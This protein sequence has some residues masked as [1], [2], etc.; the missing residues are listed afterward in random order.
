MKPLKES[1]KASGS[2]SAIRKF[3][4][5]ISSKMPDV[6]N[7]G[8]GEPDFDTPKNIKEAAKKALDEGFT[9][10]TPNAGI[11]ELREAIA[12]K[13][14]EE[15]RIEANPETEIIVT[16][17]GMQA[18]HFALSS[19]LDK[20]DKVLVPTPAWS[21][22]VP[23]ISIV[24][25]IPIEVSTSE[26]NEFK[27]SIE[28]LKKCLKKKTKAIIV[29]SPNNPTGSVLDKHE[30]EE[31]ADFAIEHDLM[32]ISDEIYEKFIYEGEHFSI[33]SLE[34]LKDK[35]ITINGFSKTYAMT[36]WRIGYA[37]ANEDIIS[38]M[39]KHQM[40][41]A[42]CPPAFIQKAAIEALTG[43][44]DSVKIMK[45]EYNKRRE[46]VYKRLNEINGIF[47]IKPKGAF[48][49]FP[50]IKSFKI[51]SEEISKYLLE[52]ARVMI[53]PGSMFGE[54][55]EGYIRIS[56]AIAY[57]K[58]KIALDKISDALSQIAIK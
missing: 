8:I 34:G 58:L 35:V 27:V 29:N 37:I 44:Q 43:P 30:I 26:K 19:I 56:Y 32:I 16:L 11:L 50:S 48:Y 4:F 20:G 57:E 42:T 15:N 33:A 18:L 21:A 54:C 1:S 47:A 28:D 22:Y 31:I 38:K 13:L 2:A 9:H 3:L 17:G 10:Y 45:E 5:E 46:L 40:Y 14:K 41:D 39:L 52:K 53:L 6:I 36:G 49:I 51:S 12:K 55:G 24:G 23:A 7:L 25:G